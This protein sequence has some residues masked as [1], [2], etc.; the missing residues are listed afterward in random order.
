MKIKLESESPA[1]WKMS[2]RRIY[3]YKF[4]SDM[5]I[6]NNQNSTVQQ[7]LQKVLG[8]SINKFQYSVCAVLDQGNRQYTNTQFQRFDDINIEDAIENHF[9]FW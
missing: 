4:S 3:M 9:V 5:N 1:P 7:S 6:K 2:N 8:K